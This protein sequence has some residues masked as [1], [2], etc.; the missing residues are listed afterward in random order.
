M[1]VSRKIEKYVH[2]VTLRVPLQ[3]RKRVAEELTRLIT[4]MM[5]DYAGGKEADILVCRSVLRDLGDPQDVAESY[6]EEARR[7]RH[8]GSAVAD[9]EEKRV[10]MYRVAHLMYQ[11]LTAVAVLFVGVG[12]LA[13][14]MHLI[15]S[16]LP[17]FIGLVLALVSI[18]GRGLMAEARGQGE[19]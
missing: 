15:D 7:R 16:V 19:Y 5:E 9:S 3:D 12:L 6:I 2:E 4:D 10:D 14:G 1:L 13:F 11:V 18:T 8:P 17:I